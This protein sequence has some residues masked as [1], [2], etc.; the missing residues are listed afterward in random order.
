[1]SVAN[2]TWQ[3]QIPT[4]DAP[5]VALHA[6][7]SPTT[8]RF[9]VILAAMLASGLFVGDWLHGLLRGEQ[10]V[11][12]IERCLEQAGYTPSLNTAREQLAVHDTAASCYASAQY[13]RAAYS[14]VSS[15]L[16]MLAGV[17]VLFLAPPIIERRRRQATRRVQLWLATSSPDRIATRRRRSVEQPRTIRSAGCT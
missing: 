5:R 13:N 17:S 10:Y 6:F 1:M 3:P 15:I 4:P 11:Q 2:S 14:L 8:T 16:V 7:P 9:V 12:I